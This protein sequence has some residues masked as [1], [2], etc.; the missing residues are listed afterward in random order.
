MG[1]MNNDFT[2]IDRL[3][4]EFS[5]KR[6]WDQFHSPKNLLL[7][8]VSEVGELSEVLLWKSDTDLE[9]FLTSQSGRNKISEE[10]ADVAIYLIRIAQKLDINL[11]KVINN[12]INLNEI[13]Y[14]I[15]K[16]KGSSKKYT[17]LN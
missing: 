16:S 12:K 1:F 6:D 4:R 15:E 9:Q 8:L 3:I 14:P 11:L 10:I 17:E 2:D 13:K 5:E 7:A